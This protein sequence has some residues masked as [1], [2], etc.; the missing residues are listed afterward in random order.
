LRPVPKLALPV[1]ALAVLALAG[2]GVRAASPAAGAP[3]ATPPCGLPASIPSWFDFG[4]VDFWGPLAERAITIATSYPP[5]AR[6]QF[7]ST[8]PHNVYFDLHLNNRVGT[9]S[10]PASSATIVDRA[11]KLFDYAAGSTACATPYIALN[12]LFGA[13]TPSPWTPSITRYRQNVLDFV[14]QLAARGARPFLLVSSQPYTGGD[15]GDWWRQVAQVSDLVR[16]VYFPAPQIWKQ[17]PILGSRTLRTSMRKAAADLLAI[18]VPPSRI[19]LMLG[20][21]T[22]KG[23]GGREGLEP[24][25]A[26]FEVVKLEALSARRVATELKLPTVWSWGWAAYSQAADDHDTA[27]A[28]C[29]YLWT[30]ASGLC[31]GPS[32]AGD[33]FDA[34]RT[35][36]QLVLPANVQC[37][38]DNRPIRRDSMAS[39]TALTGDGQVSF[40]VVLGRIAAREVYDP[41]TAQVLAAER[42]VIAL[43]FNGIRSTYL[44]AL[45]RAHA[46]L[47]VARGVIGDELR[48]AEIERRLSVPAPSSRQIA[49]YYS[50]YA[51]VTTRPVSVE[52]APWWLGNHERGLALASLAP[53]QIF[54]LRTTG[55]RTVQTMERTYD[56]QAL[57][58]AL[59]LG[60]VPFSTAR[61]AVRSALIAF[62]R[63]DAYDTWLGRR[64]AALLN[65]TVCAHDQLPQVGSIDLTSYL[66]FLALDVGP[67]T[68]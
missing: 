21:Q 61:P 68:P 35:E 19:G 43:R 18:G 40:T 60:A 27:T 58:D 37:V 10:A 29:V 42:A 65:R 53:P 12:E 38:A 32:A 22:A 6:P 39:L 11:N 9:P 50:T 26:W 30:R 16:E 1:I 64:E 34:S 31:D 5:T 67:T 3:M 15:A 56:V 63:D 28:A 2:A 55:R 33:D 14:R 13:S 36:G 66:P 7:P 44:A 54:R 20:F 46:S 59:P 8:I 62:A 48:R 4:G 23:Q 41:S 49:S 51:G 17:G 24:A 45:A 25:S 47:T 57:G 52:P